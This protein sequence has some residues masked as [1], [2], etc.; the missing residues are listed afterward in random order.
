MKKIFVTCMAVL[1]LCAIPG[2][3]ALAGEKAE[4][5]GAGVFSIPDWFKQRGPAGSLG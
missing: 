1:G 4:F 5:R 3:T 2:M